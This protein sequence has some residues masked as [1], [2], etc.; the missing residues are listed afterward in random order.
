MIGDVNLASVGLEMIDP[1]LAK[2]ILAE[3]DASATAPQARE[4]VPLD[5]SPGDLNDLCVHGPTR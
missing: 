2:Q 3:L 4:A 5:G 1:E